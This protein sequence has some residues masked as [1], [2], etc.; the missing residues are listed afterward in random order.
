MSA[1]QD[2]AQDPITL[3]KHAEAD[4]NSH[5]AK[6]GHEFCD[7]A[8]ES[9]VDA[10]VEKKFPGSAVV[11]GSAASGA[12]NN[13]EIPEQEGGGEWKEKGRP[14]KAADFAVGGVG[15]PEKRDLTYAMQHGGEDNVN[16][17]VR[18]K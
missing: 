1:P 5:A 7:S 6:K 4:L 13:R 17:N 15:A 9:G 10:V 18:K 3:A 12:G 16:F 14:F 2:A 8:L 11:Y